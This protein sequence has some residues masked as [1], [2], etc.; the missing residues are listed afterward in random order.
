[1]VRQYSP[2]R[3][4]EKGFRAGGNSR[5]AWI[6]RLWKYSGHCVGHPVPRLVWPRC[7]ASR[8]SLGQF[9]IVLLAFQTP[10]GWDDGPIRA[11]SAAESEPPRFPSKPI[12]GPYPHGSCIATKAA[13]QIVVNPF[14]AHDSETQT[15]F[16][17]NSFQSSPSPILALFGI[18]PSPV[19]VFRN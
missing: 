18:G 16:F 7:G 15:S 19:C 1:M 10:Q 13:D 14:V 5:I 8:G 11:A 17:N 12:L 6:A 4:T 2:R 9:K 3:W